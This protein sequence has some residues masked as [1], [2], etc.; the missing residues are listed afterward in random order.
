MKDARAVASKLCFGDG[1]YPLDDESQ[2]LERLLGGE[3]HFRRE[4]INLAEWRLPSNL[5]KSLHSSW[6]F[7]YHS[8]VWVDPLRRAFASSGD[9][10]FFQE[11]AGHISSWLDRH[12][13]IPE[14]PPTSKEPG[15]YSWYDMSAAWR[16][17]VLIG[18]ASV[19]PEHHDANAWLRP[20][21]ASHLN[22]LMDER[23]Y[24]GIG[25]HALH[26]N[27]ALLSLGLLL[28]DDQAITLAL[29][30]Y[31]SLLSISVDKEGVALEGSP[32]YHLFNLIWWHEARQ[33]LEIARQIRPDITVPDIPSMNPFLR[34][35]I[36]PDGKFVLVGDT[37][38]SQKPLLTVM[39]DKYPRQLMDQ[40]AQD[41]ELNY[42][43]T[44]G[45]E[46][47]QPGRHTSCYKDGFWFSRST[48][49]TPFHDQS[50]VSVRFGVG[51]KYRVHAHQDA[52]SVT[53]YPRG[54]RLL[55]DGG[56][57]SYY[58]GKN[59][60]FVKSQHAHNVIFVP[61]ATY[62]ITGESPL[63]NE[64]SNDDASLI[65][66]NVNVIERC[67][68]HRSVFHGRRKEMLIVQDIVKRTD[69]GE[70]VQLWNLG[71]DVTIERVLKDRIDVSSGMRKAS[72]FFFG[73]NIRIEIIRGQN[74]PQIGW[75]SSFEGKIQPAYA[76]LVTSTEREAKL[77]MCCIPLAE[78][79]EFRDISSVR[80]EF[81][82]EESR[83]YFSQGRR[84]F[85]SVLG[86]EP[87]AELHCSDI[88]AQS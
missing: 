78:D 29:E 6:L 69:D 24:A 84:M 4:T 79:D 11:L 47:T 83:I 80:A 13:T 20:A 77:V 7:Y 65:R 27:N 55:E 17:I 57:F 5:E 86:S 43:L 8:L 44:M 18:V 58:G 28:E 68:W 67:K 39:G 23:F 72:L 21:L 59:R 88:P 33:R 10:K 35:S 40:L 82:R 26:Q 19:I 9:E 3:V 12:G 41:P 74:E 36:A 63:D 42:V 64:T 76:V 53:Y 71:D 34:D 85:T 45:R 61:E 37:T 54:W 25:N 38:L 48:W 2:K 52:G 87:K 16:S 46:G 70:T 51:M 56:M 22:A 14:P 49:S 75:R 50:M 30:R 31:A 81:R 66:I 62:Y 32:A 73:Q 1:F 15:D 60:N